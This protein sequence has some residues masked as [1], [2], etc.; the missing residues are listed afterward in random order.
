MLGGFVVLSSSSLWS[1][2]VIIVIFLSI[3]IH[4]HRVII[5]ISSG[6][7]IQYI[8]TDSQHNNPLCRVTPIA[9]GNAQ[10]ESLSQ[11]DKEKYKEIVLDAAET[12][13]GLFGFDRTV[14]SNAK[15]KKGGRKW[16]DELREERTRD[17][18]TETM[19]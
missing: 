19:E 13:L 4:L 14:Y 2:F 7:T 6:S 10:K 9:I 16:Y 1:A 18:Q 5:V 12:V 3:I 11:Y 8:Y 15:Q 17:I